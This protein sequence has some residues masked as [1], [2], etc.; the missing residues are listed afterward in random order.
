MSLEGARL[1]RAAADAWTARTPDEAALRRRLG[2]PA[3]RDAL[4]LAEG[5]GRCL[6]CRHLRPGAGRVRGAD[7]GAPR[8]RRRSPAHRDDLRHAEREGRD[9]RRERRRARASAL[10]L[11]HRHRQERTQP[12]GPDVRCLLDLRRARRAVHRRRELLARRDR[13]AAVPRG[14]RERGDDLRVVPSER[15][16]PERPRP[17]RRAGGGHEPLPARV[18]RG[19]PRQSRRGLLRHDAGAHGRDR[20]R[21]GGASPA[22][23]P[24]GVVPASLLRPRAVRDRPGHGL[25]HGRRADERHRVGQ[26]PAPDRGERLPGCGRRGARAGARRGEPPRREHGRRPARRR[27]GDDDLPQPPRDGARGGPPSDHGRQLALLG[28][29][30]RSSLPSGQGSRQLDLAQGGRGV[31]SSSRRVSSAGSERRSS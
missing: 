4:A 20:P 26:V 5:R 6:P 17:P 25:R 27:A 13:D 19:R 9:R 21:G 7:P 11:V 23:R 24:G 12:V 22:P 1:A 31:R 29:R 30:G 16:A 14:P 15:R 18:R 8:R 2:R 10:A 28:A 3:E